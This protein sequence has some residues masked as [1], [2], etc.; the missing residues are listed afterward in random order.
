MTGYISF[1]CYSNGEIKNGEDGAFYDE[2]LSKKIKLS[3]E[4]N[5]EQLLN[6]ICKRFKINRGTNEIKVF[7]RYLSRNQA[8]RIQYLL[9]K[10]S[11]DDDVEAF[12]HSY[13][14]FQSVRAQTYMELLF[15]M[16]LYISR[17]RHRLLSLCMKDMRD[18]W[19]KQVL[20]GVQKHMKMSQ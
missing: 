14:Q 3:I 11:D 16:L 7:Y 13:L 12:I 18:I 17:K 19:Q 2:G 6:V 4:A 5:Y 9:S 8:D 20:Q 15:L 10:I 1:M